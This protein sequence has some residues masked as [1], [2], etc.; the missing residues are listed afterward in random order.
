MSQPVSLVRLTSTTA[1]KCD[2][3]DVAPEPSDGRK[4]PT[5]A[6]WWLW[7]GSLQPSCTREIFS[8]MA[9]FAIQRADL[10]FRPDLRGAVA[11]AAA[12]GVVVG[13][14]VCGHAGLSRSMAESR[15]WWDDGLLLSPAGVPSFLR[16]G[17]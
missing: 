3:P 13:Y 5:C 14:C 9:V 17:T 15:K 16:E 7:C 8:A 10:Q 11:R 4:R 1:Q 6:R 12:P 2:R